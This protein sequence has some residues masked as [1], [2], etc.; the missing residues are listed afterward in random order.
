MLLLYEVLV[1]IDPPRALDQLF[2]L[3]RFTHASQPATRV[4]AGRPYR[5]VGS[6]YQGLATHALDPGPAW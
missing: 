6:V 2:Q 1:S 4:F 5:A 3:G